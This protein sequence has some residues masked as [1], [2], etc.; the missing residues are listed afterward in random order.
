MITYSI[1]KRTMTSD[2]RG[3]IF[4]DGYSG[5]GKWKND[6]AS[7][8]VKGHGPLPLGKYRMTQM[9]KS[10][11]TG[12]GAIRLEPFPDN[13][14]YGRGDFEIHGESASHPGEASDGCIVKSPAAVR[15]ACY[16]EPDKILHVVP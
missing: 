9:F 11:R 1:G 7:C 14:M 8:N 4:S 16:A 3:L 13:V 15:L 12:P 6:V 5:N 2:S 10:A